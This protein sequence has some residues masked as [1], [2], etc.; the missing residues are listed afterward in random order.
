MKDGGQLKFSGS[1]TFYR[2]G[3]PHFR[4]GRDH[5]KVGDLGDLGRDK[6]ELASE[7]CPRYPDLPISALSRPYLRRFQAKTA[8][9]GHHSKTGD[10]G[11]LGC[12][13]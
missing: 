3:L 4:L 9:F 1:P 13:L 6:S 5:T 2:D 11:D 7:N 10:L 8:G 12:F